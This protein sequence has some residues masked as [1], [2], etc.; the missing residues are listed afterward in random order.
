MRKIG[1]SA[2]QQLREHQ[3]KM[4][5]GILALAKGEQEIL[6]VLNTVMTLSEKA[7]I[8]Q[9][10]AIIFKIQRGA[11][12]QD[13][14]MAYGASSNTISKAVDQYLKNGEGN[15]IFNRLI[16][17]YTEPEYIYKPTLTKQDPLQKAIKD[18]FK[19]LK[20]LLKNK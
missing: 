20:Q 18:S 13:I 1:K 4:L 12:Y 14:E 5:A 2:N 8:A 7:A 6:S 17:E 19:P 9:R 15:A 10:T 11:M 3:L 16:N